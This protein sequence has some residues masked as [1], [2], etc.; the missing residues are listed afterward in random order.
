M[1]LRACIKTKGRPLGASDCTNTLGACKA[2]ALKVMEMNSPGC[3]PESLRHRLHNKAVETRWLT[4]RSRKWHDPP[5]PSGLLI[6]PLRG[7]P[8][9][10]NP[11]RR[12]VYMQVSRGRDPYTSI[13]SALAGAISTR[14]TCAPPTA[15][16]QHGPLR[17]ISRTGLRFE[18]V[19]NTS[20]T[21]D[22]NIGAPRDEGPPSQHQNVLLPVRC[23]VESHLLQ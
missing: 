5:T 21:N 22:Y 4:K 2:S 20:A 18:A 16:A 13:T 12:G 7:L 14:T 1:R 9:E 6:K 8:R 10:T 11:L 17:I 23:G 15:D 3:L 19:A